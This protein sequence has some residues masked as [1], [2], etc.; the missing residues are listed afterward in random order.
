MAGLPNAVIKRSQELMTRMQ[1][2]NA[3][4][5]SG[6]KRSTDTPIAEVPQLN[7]FN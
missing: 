5:L 2:D 1:K 3:Q 7:L 6:R 4:N